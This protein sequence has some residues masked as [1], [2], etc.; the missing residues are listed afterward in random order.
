MLAHTGTGPKIHPILCAAALAAGDCQR[1]PCARPPRHR[2]PTPRG[3]APR[4]VGQGPAR[5]AAG[6]SPF[7]ILPPARAPAPELVLVGRQGR[8]LRCPHQIDQGPHPA[9][10]S[11]PLCQCLVQGAQRMQ[12][13]FTSVMKAAQN[14]WLTFYLT[15]C[16]DPHPK[17]RP[18]R[19]IL[20]ML[21]KV[22]GVVTPASWR[23]S[24]KVLYCRCSIPSLRGLTTFNVRV[25]YARN[26]LQSRSP[27]SALCAQTLAAARAPSLQR[28]GPRAKTLRT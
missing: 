8:H 3:G 12:D 4:W 26:C 11:H 21:H 6:C 25:R 9:A 27:G 10:F 18:A 20:L 28:A 19:A 15:T 22:G 2:P 16:I 1:H 5:P 13:Q 24:A 14:P 7:T 23:R 17:C